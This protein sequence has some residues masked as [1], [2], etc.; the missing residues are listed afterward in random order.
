MKSYETQAPFL[1]MEQPGNQ[2]YEAHHNFNETF[3]VTQ[4]HCH[5]YFE[6]YIHIS[7]GE[8]MGVENRLYTLSPNQLFVL[9]PFSMHGLS[10]TREMKNYE[11]A[12]LNLA[13]EVLRVL[14]CGQIDPENFFRQHTAGKVCTYQLSAA[15]AETFISCIRKIRENQSRKS[16][17]YERFGDYALMISLLNVICRTMRQN[18]PV[19]GEIYGSSIIQE[20]LDYINN[21]YTQPIRMENL[22]HSFGVSVSYLA[23]EFS[24]FT[25][26][27]VYDYVLYRRIIL[28]RQQML[29]DLSL[30]DIAYQCGFNDYSNFLRSFTKVVGM[31]P[32]QYR[33]N[34]KNYRSLECTL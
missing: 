26:R 11:R 4:F 28:A 15:D 1:P 17:P 16:D 5:D 7:G 18:D 33:K 2:G 14:G 13:P 24:R 19:E 8:Y 23:H 6:F 20:I 27:S 34:L 3:E 31:S 12:Y 10:C 9:P 30:S 22:A 25:N 29:G 32:S 21:H